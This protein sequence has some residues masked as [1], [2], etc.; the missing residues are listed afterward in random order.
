[1]AFN[2]TPPVS[3]GGEAQ[4]R[5]PRFPGEDTTPTSQKEI[6]GW[7]AYGIAAEVFAVCGVGS[8]LPLTLEQLAREHG[9]L[10]SSHLPC[11]RFSSPSTAPGN[12]TT[13]ATFRRDGTDNDQCVVSVLGLQV[14]TASFAMYTFSLAVLVQALTLISFSALA[15]YENNRKTL[16]LA[17]GFIGSMTSMLFI[18]IAPPVYILASLLVV[19]GVTC[20]GSSFVVLN[21]FLPVLVA[22]DPSIQTAHK[23]QGEELSPV[24]SNGEFVRFEDLDE[25]ISRDSDDHF[26]TGHRPKT[27]AAGSASPELQLSTRIS[28]KGVGLGY[29]AAVLVQILSILMLFALSKTSLPKISGTLPLRF[30]LLLVGIWWFSFTMVSRRWLR[31]RPG[32]PL[33]SS[34]GAARN[35][36]W[37]I[38][39]RLIG[40][41]WKSLWKTAKVAV[42]LRE[43]IIFLIAWFLLSDAMATVSG[44]AI[45]FARTELKMSTT[46]VGLLSI[47]ATLSGMAGAFLWPV[48]SRRL[49]LKS[50][51]TIMLCIA[52]FEVIPL[53]G[54]LAYIP[55]FKKWGVVGLQQPWEIFPLGI[56]HGLVS[57]GLSSYCRSF[58]GL[59]I[60]P[61]SEAAFYALYAA[62]DKGSSFI[63]PAIVGMLIDATGQVRS[64]FFFI[65]VLILL[66]I[67]LIWMVNAE[68]GRQD[69]LAMA[70]ILEKSHREHA[71][72]YGGPSEEAEGLLARDI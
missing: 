26:T 33:A 13:T 36:R 48:V 51:H 39:L 38:W 2:S 65:A 64:G 14:N 46:A 56:V 17:F 6:W 70:D 66:P 1:M 25:E 35:S 59:L 68:K 50:N 55:L 41:A 4:Q 47:T 71:S 42:K 30:V 67:P 29:C 21:S 22:N 18:F 37:R 8:F 24:N 69:G 49:R 52:L 27:K 60:P 12:G 43:V 7:Y 63:G 40:F 16:L 5:P 58:F 31:D 61:G 57:G 9:T 53:Y 11:V 10:L 28:S 72:E 54:M 45:L 44:T 15:D 19:V 62:T 3:P 20:L 32:P 23:E 34:K